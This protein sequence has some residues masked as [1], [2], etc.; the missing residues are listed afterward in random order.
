MNLHAQLIGPSE[1]KTRVLLETPA[2]GN[3]IEPFLLQQLG[4]ELS[5]LDHADDADSQLVADGFLDL[6]G[7]GSL[8]GGT[9]VWVLGRV[10]ASSGDVQDIY[11]LIGQDAGELDGV[12][13]GPG[14]GD[15]GGF[16][17]PVGG[18]DAEEEGHVLRDDGAGLFGQLDGEAGAVLETAAIVVLTV[19]GDWGEE[20]VDEVAMSLVGISNVVNRLVVKNLH[21]ESQWRQSLP[22]RR[23]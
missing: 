23:A 14:F 1:D 17:E 12:I 13:A 2:H 22:S 19:V 15:L 18:G 9:G 16:L 20:G 5:V 11:T 8:V 3:K 4:G 10:V 7:E 6:D 21:R